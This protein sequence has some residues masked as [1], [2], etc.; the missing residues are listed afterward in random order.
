MMTVITISRYVPK[1]TLAQRVSYSSLFPDGR[2]CL[3]TDP[4]LIGPPFQNMAPSLSTYEGNKGFGIFSFYYF[5]RDP[6]V[7]DLG[8]MCDRIFGVL[9]RSMG[10]FLLLMDCIFVVKALWHDIVVN[11]YVSTFLITMLLNIMF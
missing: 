5:F 2:S 7:L 6:C 9:C 8:T 3:Q 11:I 1:Q 4:V 10:F